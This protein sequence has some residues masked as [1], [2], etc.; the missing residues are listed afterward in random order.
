MPSYF[1]T[2]FFRGKVVIHT[3]MKSKK[4]L[5]TYMKKYCNENCLFYEDNS[6][7]DIKCEAKEVWKALKKDK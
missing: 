6:C 1:L 4:E 3:K 5:E 7:N 2:I